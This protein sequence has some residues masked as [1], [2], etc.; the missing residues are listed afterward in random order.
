MDGC[1]RAFYALQR[2]KDG[3]SWFPSVPM[4]QHVLTAVADLTA[5]TGVFIVVISSGGSVAV[6]HVKD[7]IS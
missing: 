6:I 2:Q 7:C 4:T 5:I 3:G 1:V